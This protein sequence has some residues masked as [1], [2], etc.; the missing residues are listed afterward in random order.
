M[1]TAKIS[2]VPNLPALLGPLVMD[3]VRDAANK[4]LMSS[5]MFVPVRTGRLKSSGHVEATQ[6]REASGRFASGWTAASV[7]YDTEY[8]SYVEFGT[9]D[10][11]TFAYLRRGAEAAGYPVSYG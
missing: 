6:A 5:Q 10:T 1:T 7:V 3:D 11:P 9:I 2:L 4:I 8:A